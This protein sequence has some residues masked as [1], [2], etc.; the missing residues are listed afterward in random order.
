[1]RTALDA[2]ATKFG[3]DATQA[4]FRL[5]VRP[6][7]SVTGSQGDNGYS[8]GLVTSKKL[9]TGTEFSIRGTVDELPDEL[10]G[11]GLNQGGRV[12]IAITQPIF[13]NFGRL[14]HGEGL[15]QAS[16]DLKTAQRRYELQKNDLV[17]TVVETY[18]SL[19]RLQRQVDSESESF[20][21]MDQ[22]HRVTKA[23]E[24]LGKTTRVDTLRVALLRGEAASRLAF[25]KERLSSTRNDFVELLGVP[26]DAEFQLSPVPVLAFEIP[27]INEAVRI[28]LENRVDYAQVIQDRED[29]LR[30]VQIARRSLLPDVRLTVGHEWR[31]DGVGSSGVFD[32]NENIWFFRVSVGTDLNPAIERANLGSAAY[33]NQSAT[34]LIEIIELSIAR[35]VQQHLL[36]HRRARQELD[37]ASRNF[38]L[39][40]S[41]AKLTRRLF[42]LGR[43]DNFSVTDAET[44]FVRSENRLFLAQS[45]SVNSG[46][47]LMRALGTLVESPPNLKPQSIYSLQ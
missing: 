16:N 20:K 11:L 41:R 45:E 39:A 6:Q 22:L 43:E 27:E 29:S 40:D 12:Q 37:I 2:D 28:A 21:R 15:I 38:D 34:K 10:I 7:A 44:A 5:S 33:R 8:Y 47:R 23:H 19:L 3:I 35:L 14:I 25:A 1:M 26:L 24:L 30:N 32:L 46:Y 17:I 31:G 42:T 36:A 4:E 9:I 18:E 13:R